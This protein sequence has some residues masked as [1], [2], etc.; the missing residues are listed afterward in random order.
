VEACA[1]GP[2]LECAQHVSSCHLRV[3]DASVGS[4]RYCARSGRALIRA[5]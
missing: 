1:V 4:S 5:T 3:R 2:G